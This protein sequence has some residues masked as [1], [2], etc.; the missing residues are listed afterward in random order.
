VVATVEALLDVVD[1]VVDVVHATE[2]AAVELSRI[3]AVRGVATVYPPSDIAVSHPAQV[4][5]GDDP[6]VSRFH[7]ESQQSRES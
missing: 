5:G 4:N 6:R 2:A 7:C 3:D 1:E